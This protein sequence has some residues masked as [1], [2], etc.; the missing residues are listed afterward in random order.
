MSN[1]RFT[2]DLAL[3]ISDFAGHELYKR[4]LVE[5]WSLLWDLG[6]NLYLKSSLNNSR[7]GKHYAES[8]LAV[9]NTFQTVIH[10]DKIDLKNRCAFKPTLRSFY[11]LLDI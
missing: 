6:F 11:E 10:I 1:N 5:T 4:R 2:K 7:K 8:I 9:L 3:I